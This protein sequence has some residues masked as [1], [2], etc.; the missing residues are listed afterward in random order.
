MEDAI[1]SFTAL[2]GADPS[3]AEYYVK[4]EAGGDLQKVKTKMIEIYVLNIP[5]GYRSVFPT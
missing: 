4:V 1:T 3:L 2:T 5:P